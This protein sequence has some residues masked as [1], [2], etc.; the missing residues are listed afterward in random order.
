[1]YCRA[2]E[3]GDH[4]GGLRALA[5]VL[6]LQGCVSPTPDRRPLDR[7]RPLSLIFDADDARETIDMMVDSLLSDATV[8]E[9]ASGR[10]P[11]LDLAALDNATTI[12]VDTR[13]LTHSI[14]TKLIR[15]QQF[16]FVDRSQLAVDL[17]LLNTD[18]LGLVDPNA[19]Y[20]GGSQETSDWYLYG[21]IFEMR[22][23]GERTVD[24]YYMVSLN[25]R[26]RRSGEILWSDT[27]EIRKSARVPRFSSKRTVSFPSWWDNPIREDEG[28]Y[29]YAAHGSSVTVADALRVAQSN[30]MDQIIAR[31][32]GG[33]VT[34]SM[35][36]YLISRIRHWS[37]HVKEEGRRLGRVDV[38]LIMKYPKEEFFSLAAHVTDG[39]QMLDM[40]HF[41]YD[42]SKFEYALNL[43][44]QVTVEY[45]MGSQP[46]FQTE[47]A[48]L[49]IADCY[50]RLGYPA[51]AINACQNVVALSGDVSFVQ[52]ANSRI[53]EVQAGY[54]D[55]VFR[56]IFQGKR[57]AIVSITELD[58]ISG[59][60]LKIEAE[61]ESLIDRAGGVSIRRN[62]IRPSLDELK[63]LANDPDARDSLLRRLALDGLLVAEA[64]GAI[65]TRITDSEGA[66]LEDFRF[67]GATRVSA[68]IVEEK[69]LIWARSGLTGWNPISAAMCMDV[70]ALNIM[71]DWQAS[72][73]KHFEEP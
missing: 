43:S 48:W 60:W 44:K 59:R 32:G 6:A 29:Y 72:A 65:R 33:A 2:A 68:Y 15:S 54:S 7:D 66:R 51:R 5:I 10:R 70:L 56:R 64:N 4:M 37:L 13:I 49:L 45:P 21:Q 53:T 40:A 69:P 9:Q 61:L 19:A 58:E 62:P 63:L 24:R 57:L 18:Q 41:A 39:Q 14:R 42:A 47:R 31:L 16:R 20:A 36:S 26:D 52:A 23:R 22:D 55:L 11:F 34:E 8:L 73:V 38:W 46:I 30:A 12:H 3:I 50:V 28:N 35:R 1:M 17:D 27:S 71:R 25:L 67:E